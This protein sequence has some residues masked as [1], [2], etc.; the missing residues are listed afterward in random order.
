MYKRMIK[1][2]NILP[3]K[4]TLKGDKQNEEELVFLKSSLFSLFPVFGSLFRFSMYHIQSGGIRVINVEINEIN[5]QQ[6]R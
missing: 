3:Q 6:Q 4:G 5:F 2:I 1:Q